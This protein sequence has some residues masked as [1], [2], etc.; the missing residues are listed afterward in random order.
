[1]SEAL[2][3]MTKARVSM[4]F[5]NPFFASLALRLQLVEDSN[6][7][8][9]Y[10][11]GSI[12]G[13][14][15]KYIESLTLNETI[16]LIAHEVL[17]VANLHHL[18]RG[19]REFFKW[20]KAADYAINIVLKDSGME[21]SKDWLL[22]E[23]YRGKSAESIYSTL[24]DDP[25][26]GSSGKGNGEGNSKSMPGEVRDAK[27]D[28]GGSLSP[29]E[30]AEKEAEVRQ[31]VAQAASVAKAQGKLPAGM[32]RFITE[33]VSPK[34]DWR[35][36][37]RK[38][39]NQNVKDDFSFQRVNSRYAHMGVYLPSLHS[40]KLGNIVVAVDTSGSVSPNELSQFNAEINSILSEYD[41][42]I[43]VLYCDAAVKRM[44]TID[45]KDLPIKLN[46]VGGGGTRF[47]PVFERVQK[48]EI[49]PVCLIYLTDLESSDFGKE[50]EYPVMWISTSQEKAPFG[51]VIKM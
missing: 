2:K 48:E 11:D 42:T 47:S 7:P 9:A 34:V 14:S 21:V 6:C 43:N 8:T 44:D 17:H 32:E 41:T 22:N 29:S 27:N 50:P 40:E 16:S 33:I 37:L 31:A 23:A 36:A 38:F 15:P 12:I 45:S 39:V 25:K 46:P 18:R 3:K 20:N 5:S 10:T 24:P 26:S 19:S 4:L 49:E 28:K 30:I 1:M 51:E 13:Y 35:D